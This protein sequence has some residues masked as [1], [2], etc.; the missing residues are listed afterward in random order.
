MKVRSYVNATCVPEPISVHND[1]NNRYLCR[2]RGIRGGLEGVPQIGRVS[3]LMCS[4]L[5]K[6]QWINWWEGMWLGG[7]NVAGVICP[8]SSTGC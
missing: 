1:I 4:Y 7:R 8:P 6:N 2:N 3:Y 5:F